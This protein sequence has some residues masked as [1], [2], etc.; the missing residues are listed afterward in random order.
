MLSWVGIL[1]VLTTIFTLRTGLPFPAPWGLLP[2]LLTGG[3]IV[4]GLGTSTRHNVI[5]HNPVMIYVGTISYSVY[6]WHMPVQ[7]MLA[8]VLGQ[9]T[10]PYFVGSLVTT[11]SGSGTSC[12]ESSTLTSISGRSDDS[13]VR[14]P[15][16]SRS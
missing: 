4:G 8:P 2:V 9:D 5:L 6:L 15:S 11:I 12:S 16:R 7:V 10:L 1:G 14:K 13:A 3:I